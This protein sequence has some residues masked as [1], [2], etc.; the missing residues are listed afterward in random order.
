MYLPVAYQEEQRHR[1][2]LEAYGGISPRR[3][4]AL[5]TSPQKV[6]SCS[7]ILN[8]GLIPQSDLDQ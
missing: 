5:D 1:G 3:F 6:N 4:L 7:H 2:S 8:R